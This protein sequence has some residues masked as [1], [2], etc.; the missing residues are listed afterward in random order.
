[1]TLV[2]CTFVGLS[3][4]TRAIQNFYIDYNKIGMFSFIF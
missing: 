1:M 4:M 2:F 3:F